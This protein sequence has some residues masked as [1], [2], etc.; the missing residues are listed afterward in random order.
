MNI[1]STPPEYADFLASP[2]VAF[3]CI[4]PLSSS[5]G[6]FIYDFFI[7]RELNP[8]IGQFDLKCFCELRPG[9]IGWVMLDLCFLA[10]AYQWHNTLPWPLLLVS[11]FHLLYVAD[12]LWNEVC[13]T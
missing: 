3:V 5:T 11:F 6:V 2:I 12:A 9:L 13:D 4:V 1:L 7:G 10:Q 8:R